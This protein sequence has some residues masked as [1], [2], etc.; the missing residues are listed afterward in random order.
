MSDRKARKPALSAR[1]A[2]AAAERG[3][4]ALAA[5]DVAL[6]VAELERAA[7]TLKEPDLVA[8]LIEARFRAGTLELTGGSLPASREHL[9]R[10]HALAPTRGD[11]AR[12]LVRTCWMTGDWDGASRAQSALIARGL[13]G[14]RMAVGDT[15]LTLA[16]AL[17]RIKQ[18]A[19]EPAG[20]LIERARRGLSSEPEAAREELARTLDLVKLV[21]IAAHG[22]LAPL[23]DAAG[24]KEAQ[25]A[26]SRELAAAVTRDHQSAAAQFIAAAKA[27]VE[28]ALLAARRE[29]ADVLSAPPGTSVPDPVERLVPA[30]TAALE[31]LVRE[32]AEVA[33]ARLREVKTALAEPWPAATARVL[34]ALLHEGDGEA[35]Q[36]LLGEVPEGAPLG[37]FLV[38]EIAALLAAGRASAAMSRL[39]DPAAG[40]LPPHVVVGLVQAAVDRLD[41]AEAPLELLQALAR[42][43]AKLSSE[44]RARL[45]GTLFA[46]GDACGALALWTS[47][48]SPTERERRGMALAAERALFTLE[49][50]PPVPA[51]TREALAELVR[52]A[53]AQLAAGSLGLL[54]SPPR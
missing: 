23:V 44:H 49:P 52:D 12:E 24:S 39:S 40:A 10:A 42:L 14:A 32:L 28:R 4:A 31:P 21:R 33:G 20:G 3:R 1:Q 41:T 8:D 37:L 25:I 15:R 29:M 11:V 6:A 9:E 7:G 38:L 51:P 2:E 50:A 26:T 48:P 19:L 54:V 53:M 35:A 47:L 22:E 18:G 43:G 34:A 16:L 17:I 27:P 46:R 30:L 13:T 36:A 5:G 45:A